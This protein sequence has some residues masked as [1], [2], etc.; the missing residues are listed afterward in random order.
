MIEVSI[1][2]IILTL[3]V[4]L[5]VGYFAKMIVNHFKIPDVTGYIILGVIAGVLFFRH[6]PELLESVEIISDFALAI[7]AFIIGHELKKDVILKLGKAIFFIAFF[8]AF[9]AFL[10][11]FSVLYFFDFFPLHTSLLLGAIASA[12]APA[13]TVFVIHQYKSRGPLT[14]TI[15]A[16]VGIDDAIALIIFVFATTVAQQTFKGGELT[17]N[18]STVS[19]PIIT[20]LSSFILGIGMG[21][22]FKLMFKNI[23]NKE[24]MTMGIVAFILIVMGIAE[25]AKLSELLAI[26]TFSAYLTNL[27]PVLAKRSEDIIV[28]FT[29]IFMPFFFIFAG[30]HL[31]ITLIPSIAGICTIY[32]LAR[33]TGKIGGAT[34]G[35]FIGGASS[36]VKKYVGLGLI[37]Q[38]GV[39]VALALAVKRI[40]GDPEGPYGKEG[41]D[42][43][44]LVI[45]ILLCS[46]I[47]TESIGPLLTKF[48]LKKS[49]EITTE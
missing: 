20:V 17:F 29:S 23:R 44:I 30:A 47:I 38:V 3:G 31:D 33:T 42:M 48:A 35:G 21:Y 8:E 25:V 19:T 43:A 27:S 9:A 2:L 46:T 34:L 32:F 6:I 49:G 26:M 39:A 16:V 37:P 36:N 18:F 41:A 7:I 22:I 14:S 24:T 13:A 4:T 1:P 11:V 15:L 12:T 40:F 10:I 5:L 45:N 28:N